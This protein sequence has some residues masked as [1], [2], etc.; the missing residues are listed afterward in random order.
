[1]PGREK[2]SAIFTGHLFAVWLMVVCPPVLAANPSVGGG[3]VIAL[4]ATTHLGDSQTFREGDAVSF[5]LS[6]D[7]DAYLVLVYQDAAG[8]LLKVFPDP[9][10]PSGFVRAG[11][12]L[13]F[14]FKGSS[15]RLR[16]TA[17]FGTESLWVFAANSPFPVLEGKRQNDG[18]VILADSVQGL[19]A[20]MRGFGRRSGMAYGEARAELMTQAAV[21]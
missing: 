3:D 8:N 13:D 10:N 5:L 12:F 7:R 6:L 15:F 19:L 11:R 9:S 1:L 4:E 16:V 20:R 14:P 2:F 17:P 18:A 21:R